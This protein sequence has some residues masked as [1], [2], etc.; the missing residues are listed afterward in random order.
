MNDL[1]KE[2]KHFI[3]RNLAL[4]NLAIAV[5]SLV[6]YEVTMYSL[7][8]W[9]NWSDSAG[10]YGGI[11][12]YRFLGMSTIFHVTGQNLQGQA[13]FAFPD[14]TSY[15]LL[16]L[17]ILNLAALRAGLKAVASKFGNLEGL[18]SSLIPG[19]MCIFAYVWGTMIYI[20]GLLNQPSYMSPGGVLSYTFALGYVVYH[21]TSGHLESMG[22]GFSLDFT[23]WLLFII[24]TLNLIATI[25]VRRSKS[26]N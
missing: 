12:D 16:S 13:L 23:A 18:Y 9:T 22:I 10:A 8:Y 1:I 4:I 26:Q 14:V 11:L 21:V 3:R 20:A 17:I 6:S 2:L 25:T 7:A 24:I 15:L 19:L 5:C